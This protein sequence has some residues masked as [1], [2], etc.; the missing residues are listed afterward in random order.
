MKKLIVILVVILCATFAFAQ[1]PKVEVFGG[2]QYTSVDTKDS[3]LGRLNFNGWDADVA[4]RINKN[5]SIVGDFSGVYKSP[6]LSSLVVFGTS[7]SGTLRPRAVIPT[8]IK[9]GLYNYVFGPR[10]T[11][12]AGK[13][14]PF[15]EAL[16]GMNHLSASASGVSISANGFAMAFGGGLDINASKR[17]G[18]RLAKFDYMVNRVENSDLGLTPAQNLNNFRIATGIVFKF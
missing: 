5:F 18:I 14:S 13:I 17:I 15:A 3:G 6:D 11:M 2:Y 12:E 16:F 9:F 10:V 4:A 8:D 1:T 7:P